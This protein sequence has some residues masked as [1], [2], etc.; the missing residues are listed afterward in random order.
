MIK[1]NCVFIR[2]PV[3]RGDLSLTPPEQNTNPSQDSFNTDTETVQSV[4][5]QVNRVTGG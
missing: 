1:K 3:A 4:E 2:S 5:E